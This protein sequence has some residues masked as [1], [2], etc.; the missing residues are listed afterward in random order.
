MVGVTKLLTLWIF[1]H[2]DRLVRLAI[3]T[4]LDVRQA[5]AMTIA[6]VCGRRAFLSGMLAELAGR[7]HRGLGLLRGGNKQ[8]KN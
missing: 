4:E 5:L 3:R 7:Q 1:F 6:R 2:C 8:R